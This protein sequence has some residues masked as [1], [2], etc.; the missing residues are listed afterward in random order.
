MV[1]VPTAEKAE[2]FIDSIPIDVVLTDER[3]FSWVKKIIMQIPS[4]N[5][6]L[7]SEM[8]EEQFHEMTEGYGILMKLSSLPEKSDALHLLKKVKQLQSLM[9]V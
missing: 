4:L 1:F 2:E 7:F 8:T 9:T 5:I 6:A 3:N